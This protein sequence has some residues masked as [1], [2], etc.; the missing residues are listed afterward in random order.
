VA[1]RPACANGFMASTTELAVEE[2]AG[3]RRR[4]DLV[5]CYASELFL[6]AVLVQV[7]LAGVGVFG[8]HNS[9]VANASSFDPHRALGSVLG[10]VAV[11]LFVVALLV[12]HSRTTMIAAFALGILAMAAQPALANGGDSNKWVGG[13]HALD[14]M[15][16]LGLS[17]W[18]ARASYRRTRTTNGSQ[19]T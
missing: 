9:K 11:V 16:I 18:I 4:L 14:G 15:I 19:P 3:W 5:Y 17:G 8:D 7:F 6:A 13:L 12:R 10:L 1:R 2:L